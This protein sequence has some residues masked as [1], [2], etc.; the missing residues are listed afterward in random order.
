ML[1]TSRAQ[2]GTAKGGRLALLAL[3]LAAACVPDAGRPDRTGGTYREIVDAEDARPSGGPA[4][5]TLLDA[6]ELDNAFMRRTA[7]RALGRLENPGLS[8]SIAPL[9]EDPV[10]AVRGAAAE[11]LAQSV[12]RGDGGAV[13]G[14]LLE[15]VPREADAG[16]R[17][18]LAHSLG[19]LTLAEP[20]RR[21]V[22]GA[23]VA[24]AAAPAGAQVDAP[25][26]T[27]VGVASGFE[28]LTRRS[29]G[30]PLDRPA[31]DV[32]AAL[33]TYG[34]DGESEDAVATAGRIRGLAVYA[35]GRSRRLSLE[36]MRT[37]AAD[38][39]PEVRRAILGFMNASPPSAREGLL[40]GALA[41]TSARV[42]TEAV[43][44]VAA[45]SRTE[46]RCEQLMSAAAP[47]AHPAVRLV[48]LAALSGTCPSVGPQ[49][50][51]LAEVAAELGTQGSTWQPAAQA[52]VS[53]ARLDPGRVAPLLPAFVEH[54]SP[55][56]RA[57]AA[58]A[59]RET[60]DVEALFTLGID[61]SPNVRTEALRGLFAVEGHGLDDFLLEQLDSDDPQLLMT[62]AELLEGAPDRLRVASALLTTFERISREQRETWRDSRLALLE[63]IEALGD[64]SMTRDLVPFLRDY[65]PRVAAAVVT[66]LEAWTGGEYTAEP[67]PL[68]R[69]PVPTLPELRSLERST[70]TL[71]MRGGNTMVIALLADQATTNVARVVRLARA[72]Y[73]DGLTFHRW[74]PNFV[75]Q[76]GSPGANEYQ[77]DGAYTRDEVGGTPHWRGTV[78]ISTRGRDTGDGQLFINLVDNPRLDHDY[79]VVGRLVS[80]DDTLDRV[81]EGDV[82][83]RAEVVSRR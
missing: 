64:E 47:A 43:R 1:A 46:P 61:P 71:H 7:V 83:E 3:I 36:L 15:R 56:V 65:D 57:Y 26:E 41:D 23:L 18:I 6:L 63:R 39:E 50:T 30:A 67:E 74:A 32:L 82:I 13:L 44:Y 21:S 51:L 72:G 38:P 2:P 49:R 53:L 55:F 33:M 16:V 25:P 62:V 27:L 58:R 4:L 54:D 52:L 8:D 28:S 24:L 22:E 76:G 9:L 12:H 60:R 66:V 73:Y 19:R 45:R 5:T 80:G 77:G 11:A 14:A 48:A 37:A 79:T 17:G 20:H 75:I 35:L 42:A 40:A 70:L 29:P 31:A 10:A 78:G 69:A 81:L 59:A 34:G 68:P